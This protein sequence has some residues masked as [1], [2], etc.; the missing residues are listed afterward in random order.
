MKTCFWGSNLETE[1][2]V[3]LKSAKPTT[4][5]VSPLLLYPL[6]VA[7]VTLLSP[8]SYAQMEMNDEVYQRILEEFLEDQADENSPADDELPDTG[9]DFEALAD[10]L[11]PQFSDEESDVDAES[12]V[13]EEG[14]ADVSGDFSDLLEVF[15]NLAAEI[16]DEA[17][18]D[19]DTGSAEDI[20]YGAILNEY[21]ES[22]TGEGDVGADEEN[23]A[24]LE[25]DVQIE[26]DEPADTIDEEVVE[27]ELNELEED[28][29]QEIVEEETELLLGAEEQQVV[30]AT[31]EEAEIA[32]EEEVSEA[33]VVD[34]ENMVDDP[35]AE[36]AQSG[37]TA[38]GSGSRGTGD[39]EM[40]SQFD[41]VLESTN[42][43]QEDDDTKIH[44]GQW[45]VM[46]QPEIFNELFREGYFF[47]QFTDLPS[48]GLR[49]AEVSAP[50]SFD[51]DVAR[52]G[53][54]DVVG[55]KGVEVDL[56]HF[57]TAGKPDP[58]G[59]NFGVS[60][61]EAMAL[62]AFSFESDLRI[63]IVDSAVDEN[64][65]ALIGASIRKRQFTKQTEDLPDFHGTAIASMF[66][67]RSQ[68]LTGL[69][70]KSTLYAAAVFDLDKTNGEVA[71]T[72]SLIRAL[73]W[74]LE[75]DVDVVN[76][77]LTGPPNRLLEV[78][79]N[80]VSS[81]GVV[82]VAAAGNDGPMASPKYPAAYPTVI[83]VTA[84]DEQR[85][86]FRLANRG[87][88]LSIAAPGV[89]LRHAVP[90]GGYA[91][92][93]GTSFAVPF[94]AAAA[95]LLRHQRPGEDVILRLYASALD[96]GEPGRDDIYGHGLLSVK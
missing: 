14:P 24:D 75:T 9:I 83:A 43:E 48:L 59:P 60:P 92:S 58:V 67:A 46:A 37:I 64:H 34:A 50:A 1:M 12:P 7:G 30:D 91:V 89:N 73:D 21:E 22:L 32:V 49:I 18:S 88:Y 77:S 52:D 35:L 76:L 80:K 62:P 36:A 87:D 79:V 42:T 25:D 72:I 55:G 69:V 41:E 26:E 56:N 65:P 3:T 82:V 47:D 57:Y 16:E 63:G 33:V 95:A 93:S 54:Y 2:P 17:D 86:A 45:L 61:R 10:E 74:M 90:G 5:R 15:Q 51:I 84:V 20:D 94:V 6:F 71:S 53:I 85:R 68:E 8:L 13:E 66:V 40:P 19:P 27:D 81:R 39:P 4:G 29:G 23:V 78:A 38:D 96:L 44:L 11:D 70:P 28:A 31:E